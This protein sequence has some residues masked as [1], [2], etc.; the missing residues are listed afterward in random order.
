MVESIL[1]WQ[2]PPNVCYLQRKICPKMSLIQATN[3]S[4]YRPPVLYALC[5]CSYSTYSCDKTV[6]GFSFLLLLF[7]CRILCSLST[8]HCAAGWSPVNLCSLI[9]CLCQTTQG[10][11]LQILLLF[12]GQNRIQLFGC[13]ILQVYFCTKCRICY[14]K[15]YTQSFIP[16]ILMI[17]VCMLQCQLIY[18]VHL[19][20]NVWG[21]D[22]H[23]QLVG[24]MLASFL[25]LATV[26]VL[27][28]VRAINKAWSTRLFYCTVYWANRGMR[29]SCREK[30]LC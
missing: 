9:A 20:C 15:E 1:P 4:L 22:L 3:F 14:K 29:Q 19:Q 21:L 23:E 12:S 28:H 18:G 25:N 30:A 16:V 8:D 13:R 2:L 5:S 6:L 17:S 26:F 11:S 27:D 7:P 10:K 24:S